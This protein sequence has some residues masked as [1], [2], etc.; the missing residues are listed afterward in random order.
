MHASSV[1]DP[2]PL[3]INWLP[4]QPDSR[5]LTAEE[6]S[7]LGLLP[8]T[9]SLIPSFTAPMS[10]LPQQHCD[11][12]FYGGVDGI[13]VDGIRASTTQLQRWYAAS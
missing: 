10:V 7:S 8:T 4:P 6:S 3:T 11:G 2:F 1:S 12:V 13:R 5:L 9:P